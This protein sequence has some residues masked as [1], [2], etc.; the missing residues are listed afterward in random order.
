M[1]FFSL[2]KSRIR[3]QGAGETHRAGAEERGRESDLQYCKSLT[4]NPDPNSQRAATRAWK[5]LQQAM[6]LVPSGETR[7]EHNSLS[8]STDRSAES[9]N[10]TAFYI[11]RFAV[12]HAEFHEFVISGV[13][14]DMDRWP[15]EIWQH[16]LQFV[17]RT[18][19][20]G[21]QSW[22]HG[23]P[24]RDKLNHPVTGICWYE[25]MA[26]A[27]WVGKRLPNAAQWQ[28]AASWHTGQNGH[29]AALSYPWGNSF[30]SAKAN[31]W[32]SRIGGTVAVDEYY[33]GCTPNGV[34]Q[35][36]GNVWEWVDSAFVIPWNDNHLLGGFAEI[37]GGAFDTYFESQCRCQFRSGLPLL[38]R[39]ANVGFRCSVPLA[40]LHE[41]GAD[42]E[43]A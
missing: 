5:R 10:V 42:E 12:T 40:D 20:P 2:V 34:H 36:I 30:D 11:D 17:D 27:T 29:Q 8:D 37:R 16:V 33:D 25:A 39:G 1:S 6:A 24:P 18:G 3:P 26:F 9:L 21:P 28:R 35:L 38:F 14:D 31:T 32:N 43:H 19:T 41:P 23:K 15:S 13:Y 7:L 22:S 4:S